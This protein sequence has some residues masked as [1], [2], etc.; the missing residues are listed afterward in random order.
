METVLPYFPKSL[1][2]IE[3]LNCELEFNT[4]D[5]PLCK[6]LQD[7]IIPLFHSVLPNLKEMKVTFTAE[8]DY[9]EEP[10]YRSDGAK[11]T[12]CSDCFIR[13][14]REASTEKGKWHLH[15]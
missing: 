9:G 11:G 13:Y 12:H 10:F 1:E 3:F 7:S 15:W 6:A 14:H 2:S 4:A 8:E 5:D